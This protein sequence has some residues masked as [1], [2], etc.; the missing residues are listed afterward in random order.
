MIRTQSL[1][2]NLTLS[3]IQSHTQYLAVDIMTVITVATMAAITE[4]ITEAT[5]MVDTAEVMVVTM[6]AAA[7]DMEVVTGVDIGLNSNVYSN[8]QYYFIEC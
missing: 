6:A 7:V 4:V 2:Q 8:S 3:P 5:T 1:I